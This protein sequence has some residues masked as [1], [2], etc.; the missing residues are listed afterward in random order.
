VRTPSVTAFSRASSLRE[1]AEGTRS[2]GCG[3]GIP[4]VTSASLCSASYCFAL[5]LGGARGKSWGLQNFSP[6]T[7]FPQSRYASQLPF[8]ERGA[9]GRL[10]R[11][12]LSHGVPPCQLPQRGSQG[13][14]PHPT[15]LTPHSTLHSPHSTL[16][17]PPPF[18]AGG[19]NKNATGEWWRVY[20]QGESDSALDLIGAEAS[21]TSVHMAGS[22][23]NDSLNALDVGLPC[24]IGT[25]VGVR[26]LDTKRHALTTKITL[27]HLLHL[28]SGCFLNK[29]R[30]LKAP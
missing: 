7:G 22:S 23:V 27:S 28:P 17:S 20:Q 11:H 16:R 4:S 15:L 18:S 30:P 3:S 5:M 24:T 1:G 12:S 6:V 29:L 21:G 9:F 26:D 19:E 8:G 14:F 13:C 10:R 25:S 2:S